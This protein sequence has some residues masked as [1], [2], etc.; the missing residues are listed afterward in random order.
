MTNEVH[1]LSIT[2]L[3]HASPEAVY[4]VWTERLGEWW[5]PKPYTTPVVELDLRPGG[6]GLMEMRAPDG[7]RMPHEGVF[8]EVVPN[9]KIVSTNAFTA[10]W[11]P[12][13]PFM[14]AIWT[15]EPEGTGTRYTARVRHWSAEATKRHEDMG[16]HVGWGIVTDQLAALAEAPLTAAAA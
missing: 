12:Q 14:V 11:I 7:T 3:I 5:A 13:E 10:G 15:F 9:R 2:R 16:F 1:E 8:L 6:R 4:R